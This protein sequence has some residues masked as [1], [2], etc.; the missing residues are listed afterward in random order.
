M[1]TVY[2]KTLGCKVNSYDS[3]ALAAQFKALGYRMVD[4]ASVASVAVINTCSVTAKA[5]R[6]SRYIFR[7]L[8]R[9][10]PTTKVVAT[11]CYAQVDSASISEL[12]E[13]DYVVPNES[14]DQL[15]DLIT[16]ALDPQK[17]TPFAENKLPE[18][19]EAVK[20]NRQ[21]HFK[22]SLESYPRIDPNRTRAFL[23]IQDGC[24][25]FCS[26]CLI[27]YARGASRS[28]APAKVFEEV[29]RLVNEGIKEIVFTG[30]HIGDY[31]DD[32]DN[33]NKPL[34][35]LLEKIFQE[36]DLK[37]FRISSL[38]PSEATPELIETLAKYRDRVCDHFHLPLQAGHDRIL[39]LMRR[40]YD[41][42]TYRDAVVRI[43]KSFPTAMIG[44]DI[45]PGFPSET[46]EEHRE[47]MQFIKDVGIN[48]LHVFPY[49]KRPNTAA[50]KMAG[51][52]DPQVIKSRAQ[53]LRD[54]S[55]ELEHTYYSQNVGGTHEVLWESDRDESGRLL[56]HTRNYLSVVAS[57]KLGELTTGEI[58][59]AKLIGFCQ[60]NRLLAGPLS[61]SH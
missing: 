18:T 8:K 57:P 46:H 20:A 34:I 26:Y 24:N 39:K 53:E 13:V 56:G 30:I 3:D 36:T 1:S 59:Q 47:T 2:I 19:V 4:D 35:P 38:E 52:L 33:G 42:G 14:K 41:L 40:Q 17:E 25:G 60:Q 50:G 23:K 44:A 15:A 27:P 31:G 43:K 61:T 9:D 58:S 28:V 32:L 48:S 22:S 11:G 45:I 51:H 12:S 6:D 5:D 7:R 49:S 10:N 16:Q 37:R 54:L 29:S 55:K 21:G